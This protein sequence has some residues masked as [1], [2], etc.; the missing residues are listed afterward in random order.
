MGPAPERIPATVRKGQTPAKSQWESSEN[1]P[2]AVIMI[3]PPPSS[4]P[5]SLLTTFIA[6]LACLTAKKQLSALH[7]LPPFPSVAALT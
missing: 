3:L 4:F 2:D 7:Q 5:V 1:A 6:S